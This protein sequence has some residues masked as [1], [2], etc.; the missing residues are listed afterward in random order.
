M[1]GFPEIIEDGVNGLLFKP[2]DAE[3][4]ANKISILWENKELREKL[5]EAGF[6]KLNTTYSPEVYYHKLVKVYHDVINSTAS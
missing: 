2:G 1:A 6:K 3:D 4:L 5:G